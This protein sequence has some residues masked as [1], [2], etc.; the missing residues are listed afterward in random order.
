MEIRG[1]LWSLIAHVIMLLIV[2]VAR[3]GHNLL[4]KVD[5][6]ICFPHSDADMVMGGSYLKLYS[7][8]IFIFNQ[9]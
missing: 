2:V 1:E 5:A 3:I 9:L 6:C 8:I 4:G 7:N